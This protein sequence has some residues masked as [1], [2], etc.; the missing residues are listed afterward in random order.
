L[1]LFEK[2]R[3]TPTVQRLQFL[4]DAGLYPYFRAIGE[5]DLGTHVTV[6][7][8]RLVMAGSN[9]YLGLTHHPQVVEATKAAISRY[10]TGCTG[11]RFLN[12][13]LELH[14]KLEER[15]ARF[16]GREAEVG[17]IEPGKRADLILIDGDPSADPAALD[18]FQYVFKSGVGY[19]PAVIFRGLQG[20]VGLH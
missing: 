4:R 19:D 11:S 8:R 1:D 6:R 3:G 9:N 15:L 14:E 16:L 2:L 12:G 5:T 20:T 10:G 13:T 18:R 17:S 7:G